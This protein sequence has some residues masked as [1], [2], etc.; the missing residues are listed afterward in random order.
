MDGKKIKSQELVERIL[1][2]RNLIE[3]N[4]EKFLNPELLD[5]KNPF[6]FENMDKIIDK[7]IEVHQTAGRIFIY[8]DY[9]VD[10][11]SGT[12]FLV[13]F[14]REI[15]YDVD[16]YIPNR[17]ESEYGVSRE[18]I[19]YFYKNNGKLVITVDTGYNTMEDVK[20]ARSLGMDVIVTD[21]HKTVKESFDDEILYLNPKLSQNYK[22][23]SLSG[24]GVAFKL[25]QGI[26]IR[27]NLDMGLI[28]K[29][30]DIVMIGTIADVVPMIDENRIIIKNGLK[31]IKNT[32]VKGLGY[33]LNYLRLNRKDVTTTDVS[34]YISP[35]INSL[36]RV[37]TS[38]VGADFFIKEDDFDLYNIIEDMKTLNK[39]RRNLEKFIYDD[40]M[41]KIHRT[42]LDIREVPVLILSSPKWHSGVIGVVSSRLSLKFNKPVI[43][44]AFEGEYGKAS[45]RSVANI[46]I[47]NLLADVKHLL[48]RYGG[49]DLAAGFVIHK[50]KLNDL[51]E[52][53]INNTPKIEN[54]L[55]VTKNNDLI[56][57]DFDISIDEIDSEIFKFLEIMGPFGSQN[58]HVLFHSKGVKFKNIKTFGVDYRH[59]NSEIIRNG[60]KYISVGF[61]LAEKVDLEEKNDINYDIIYYPEKVFFRDE[62]HI[63]IVLKDIAINN[64]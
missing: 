5:F 27:L 61:D 4:M 60:K 41:K 13:R 17:S 23:K 51:K 54:K 20:Y 64:K 35:L 49:H 22:F 59:F 19:D 43:L 42:G 53:L 57:Y 6:D 14:F 37:G 44:I 55:A 25:A 40:A 47:F 48:V 10:G 28:Y 52:Y 21:H 26:C 58:P 8:G 56:E 2:K 7:I 9:D 33:L 45:C 16:Y 50:N 39:E 63:Q 11:I 38:K 24:A 15:N 1:E 31:I 34:Y 30:L 29:Y 62:E 46:S 12:S 18:N 32:K 3:S 36:G